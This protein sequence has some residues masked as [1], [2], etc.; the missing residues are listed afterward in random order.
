MNH[1]LPRARLPTGVQTF[2]EVRTENLCYVDKTHFAC[3]L[4]RQGKHYFLSRPRRF[5]KSL[6]VSTLKALF[7]GRRDLFHGLAADDQWDWS[8]RRPVA[9]LSFASGHYTKPDG[10]H[11]NLLRQLNLQRLASDI[12][13]S[14]VE[15]ADRFAELLVKLHY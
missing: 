2:R 4:S 13:L 12:T 5:G 7:E 11:H 6:F 8:V 14:E 9:R 1:A 10:L 15:G 3:Q